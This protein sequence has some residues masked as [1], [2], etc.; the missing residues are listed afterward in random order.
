MLAYSLSKTVGSL[1]QNINIQ[2]IYL[3]FILFLLQKYVI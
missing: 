1:F 3:Y 2:S